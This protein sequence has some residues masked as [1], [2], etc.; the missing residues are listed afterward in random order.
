MYAKGR[1]SSTRTDTVLC[2]KLAGKLELRLN[3]VAEISVS[4]TI[5]AYPKLNKAQTQ[6]LCV[7]SQIFAVS[8]LA[9]G[10]HSWSLCTTGSPDGAERRGAQPARWL[11]SPVHYHP[12]MREA[13]AHIGLDLWLPCMRSVFKPAK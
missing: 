8:T 6:P 1:S 12:D 11:G 5:S 13:A 7:T 3:P 4:R 10:L 9:K 2:S